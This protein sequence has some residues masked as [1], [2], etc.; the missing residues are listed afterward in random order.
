MTVG[1]R[2]LYGKEAWASVPWLRNDVLRRFAEP[3]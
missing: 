2:K 3:P 1:L